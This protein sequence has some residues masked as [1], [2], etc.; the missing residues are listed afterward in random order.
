MRRTLFLLLILF[1]GCVTTQK[2]QQGQEVGCDYFSFIWN[3]ATWD[4]ARSKEKRFVKLVPVNWSDGSSEG[5][6]FS[7]R[8]YKSEVYEGQ[9]VPVEI[10]SINISSDSYQKRPEYISKNGT[11]IFFDKDAD[12]ETLPRNPD[13]SPKLMLARYYKHI[14]YSRKW[15]R[16]TYLDGLKCIDNM[17][18]G[19]GSKSYKMYCGYYDKTS[20]KRILRITFTYDSPI[21]SQKRLNHNMI[22][23]TGDAPS[24]QPIESLLKQATE[25]LISTIKIKNMDR[26]RMEREGLIYHGKTYEISPY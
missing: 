12:Y 15:E 13:G 17:Y 8:I 16:I 23:K 3:T 19:I 5:Q 21:F 1:S 20:V 10:A 9:N 11:E 6:G 25:Q 14:I 4:L 24:V 7:L 2:L 18:I 22:V 26:E